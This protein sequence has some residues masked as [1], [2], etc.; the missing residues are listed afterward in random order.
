MGK[1]ERKDE[2]MADSKIGVEGAKTLSEMMKSNTTLTTRTLR[3]EE[4]KKKGKRNKQATKK[5]E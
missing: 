2:W 1:R 5:H 4:K 3:G